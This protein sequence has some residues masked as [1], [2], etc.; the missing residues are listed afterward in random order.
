[1]ASNIASPMTGIS[2]SLIPNAAGANSIYILQMP[3]KYVKK[4]I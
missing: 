4:T 3:S 2:L 1:M